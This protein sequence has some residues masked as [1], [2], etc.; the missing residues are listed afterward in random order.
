MIQRFTHITILVKDQEEAL[1]FYTKKLGFEVH[2]DADFQGM[3]WLTVNPAGQKDME[4]CL[5][6]A[7]T[8]E[9]LNEVG[10]Q[11]GSYGIGYLSTDDA[12]KAYEELKNAGVQVVTEPKE[13]PWGI[14]FSFKDLYGNSF[15]LNQLPK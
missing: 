1:N 15:Y 13:E 9:G 11:G 5:L 8:Q 3:R 4:F 12:K 6:Q 10:K 7:A 2:T 14:G